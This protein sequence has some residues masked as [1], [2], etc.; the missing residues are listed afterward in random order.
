MELE[1]ERL[2]ISQLALSDAPF[3][4]EL[5]NDPDWIR[6][7]GDRQVRTIEDAKSYLKNRIIA[8]YSKEGFGFHKVCLKSS[9]V[10]IGITG[11]IH[12]NELSAPDIGFAFLASGRKQ[13]FAYESTRAVYDMAINQLKI[14]PILAIA[15]QDNIRSHKLLNKLGLRFQQLIQLSDEDQ[16]ICLFSNEESS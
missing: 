9:N 6:F 3:F 14:D 12:R 15:N 10:P 13:G 1:T 2:I 8:S 11:L 7:I 16:E 5:V 4:L